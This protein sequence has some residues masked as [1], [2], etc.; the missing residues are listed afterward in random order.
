MNNLYIH[1]II[2]EGNFGQVKFLI[3]GL[4]SIISW[5]CF[6]EHVNIVCGYYSVFYGLIF[7]FGAL[8]NENQAQQKFLMIIQSYDLNNNYADNNMEHNIIIAK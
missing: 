7:C 2:I 1:T 6:P 3:S 5:S 4:E 8:R